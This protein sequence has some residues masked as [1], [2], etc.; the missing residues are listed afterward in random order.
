MAD[1]MAMMMASFRS[2][3]GLSGRQ[4]PAPQQQQQDVGLGSAADVTDEG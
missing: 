2:G 4:L 1:S 3:S